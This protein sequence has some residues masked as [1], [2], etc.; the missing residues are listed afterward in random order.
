MSSRAADPTC[1]RV[2]GALLLVLAG[3]A[4]PAAA[5]VVPR[6]QLTL[7]ALA[8]RSDR[9]VLTRVQGTADPV[10]LEVLETLRGRR[11]PGLALPRGEL[12]WTPGALVLVFVDEGD[13]GRPRALAHALQRVVVDDLA[14][15][16]HLVEVV[17]E[18]LPRVGGDPAALARGLFEQLASPLARVRDDAALDLLR[19]ERLTAGEGERAALAAAL[20]RE[21]S[22][23]LLL[24]AARL[25]SPALL[26]PALRAAREARD[27]R[28]LVSAAAALRAIDAPGAVPA[29]LELVARPDE[30][31]AARAALVLGALGGAATDEAVDEAL[32]EPRPVVRAAL[33]DG[34]AEAARR[35]ALDAADR[36]PAL[37]WA[38]DPALAARGLAL[39]A[40]AGRGA[41]LARAEAQH[42]DP[43]L[44]ALAARLRGDPVVEAERALRR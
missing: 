18:R 31:R 29:L 27:P 32:G 7:G 6:E 41:D 13:D 2:L 35:G 23:E 39:L 28:V 21:A 25:P 8:D 22:A 26:G 34:L 4:A 42:P 30:E 9:I 43:T 16:A 14:A 12:A 5:S 40:L 3:A 11:A 38:D 37:A 20:D 19:R 10:P 24:L 15:A 36:L 17:R 33:L 1:T 44:R